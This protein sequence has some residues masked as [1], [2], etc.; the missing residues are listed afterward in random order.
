M[1]T[2][3][4]SNDSLARCPIGAS[5]NVQEVS[6]Q[7]FICLSSS[8]TQRMEFLE[9]NTL[10]DSS[11]KHKEKRSMIHF[12]GVLT[13][14]LEDGVG[15]RVNSLEAKKTSLEVN[16]RFYVSSL[17]IDSNVMAKFSTNPKKEKKE[18]E[19]ENVSSDNK[20]AAG[21][22]FFQE[23]PSTITIEDEFLGEKKCL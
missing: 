11:T 7:S 8:M 16:S 13:N 14:P 18:K 9:T 10:E 23:A 2:V 17:S 22:S 6:L 21:I 3:K 19:K 15:C 12:D 4:A 1:E 5:S 20:E